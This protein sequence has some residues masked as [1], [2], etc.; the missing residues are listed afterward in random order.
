MSWFNIVSEKLDSFADFIVAGGWAWVLLAIIVFIAFFILKPTATQEVSICQ[1]QT[2]T[3]NNKSVLYTQ[4]YITV[5]DCIQY[6]VTKNGTCYNLNAPPTIND[7][8]ICM[9]LGEVVECPKI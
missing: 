1:P 7:T 4:C 9:K 8:L 5:T 3:F 6:N 2:V